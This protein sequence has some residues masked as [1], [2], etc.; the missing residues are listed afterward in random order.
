VLCPRWRALFSVRRTLVSGA[1]DT[2]VI[3]CRL[4]LVRALLKEATDAVV[5][6]RWARLM[7]LRAV[8]ELT[9]LRPSSDGRAASVATDASVDRRFDRWNFERTGHVATWGATDA[10]DRVCCLGDRRVRCPRPGH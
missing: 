8:W 10:A 7:R 3:V 9:R 1:T 5:L 6:K 2:D 4:T